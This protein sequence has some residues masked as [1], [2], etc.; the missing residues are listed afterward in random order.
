ML[1]EETDEQGQTVE[2]PLTTSFQHDEQDQTVEEH[3]TISL[4]HSV[5]GVLLVF[6]EYFLKQAIIESDIDNC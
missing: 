3:T 2:E 1:G 4:Q 5:D 6:F